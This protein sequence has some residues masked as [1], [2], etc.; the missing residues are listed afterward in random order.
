[1]CT[2]QS[3]QSLTVTWLC[4]NLEELSEFWWYDSPSWWNLQQ[5]SLRSVSMLQWSTKALHCHHVPQNSVWQPSPPTRPMLCYLLT[6]LPDEWEGIPT[7]TD[8]ITFWSL[9]CVLMLWGSHDMQH[10]RLCCSRL[11]QLLRS[12]RAVLPCVLLRATPRST[13]GT[14]MTKLDQYFS[15]CIET[16]R[17]YNYNIFTKIIV[18]EMQ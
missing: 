6:I 16:A 13:S 1:M 5:W 4:A 17:G 7:W 15:A 11:W 12:R 2:G 14:T 8:H 9:F 18:L 3:G 10:Q